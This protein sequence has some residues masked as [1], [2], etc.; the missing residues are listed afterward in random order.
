MLLEEPRLCLLL[1]LLA[2]AAGCTAPSDGDELASMPYVPEVEPTTP[3]IGDQFRYDGDDGTRLEGSFLRTE[4]RVGPDLVR[5]DALVMRY[6]LHY[7]DVETDEAMEFWFEEALGGDGRIIQQVA[8][9]GLLM[10]PAGE[11]L[12]CWG[13]R[14]TV[15]FGASGLP[16]AF[17]AG[18]LWDPPSTRSITEHSWSQPTQFTYAHTKGPCAS[19]TQQIS[20]LDNAGL[21]ALP[22]SWIDATT[23]TLCD[24]PVPESF[25]TAFELPYNVNGGRVATYHLAEFTQGTGAVWVP[26]DVEPPGALIAMVDHVAPFFSQAHAPSAFPPHEAHQEA[27]RLVPEYAALARSYPSGILYHHHY[28]S[29]YGYAIDD[30][31]PL[32]RQAT[33]AVTIS[34]L[35]AS[36]TVVIERTIT[37]LGGMNQT[38]Y[39]VVEQRPGDARIGGWLH[40]QADVAEAIR[41]A[42]Q[43]NP[44][45]WE[46]HELFWL[47]HEVRREG[48]TW[49]AQPQLPDWKPWYT[50]IVGFEDP[51]AHPGAE[52]FFEPYNVSFDGVTGLLVHV[53]V[54]RSQLP[55]RA[56][57]D[58]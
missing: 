27:M 20:L 53:D 57:S 49:E 7:K 17:G 26:G 4:P 12:D 33:V 13:N 58:S 10:S 52:T 55:L 14:S 23:S 5:R 41:L 11:T 22:W 48:T 51:E 38:K 42:D 25:Q 30:N 54:L 29:G 18:L 35:R 9:C 40:S 28:K 21:R 2:T 47:S 1:L 56:P 45:P 19:W 36:H 50:V 24:H 39:E 32:T 43:I 31:D 37:E 44:L 16:G 34:D 46:N 6:T 3:R 15:L 8:G